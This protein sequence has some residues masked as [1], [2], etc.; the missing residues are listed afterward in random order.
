MSL[1]TEVVVPAVTT[2]FAGAYLLRM[3]VKPARNYAGRTQPEQTLFDDGFKEGEQCGTQRLRQSQATR[4]NRLELD[5]VTK[6][7]LLD[8]ING[9]R[10]DDYFA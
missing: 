8:I 1:L 6:D 7:Q 5:D 9:T 2:G 3:F 10:A 4:V